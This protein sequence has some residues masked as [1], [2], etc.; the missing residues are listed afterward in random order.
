MYT[1][2][3]VSESRDLIGDTLTVHRSQVMWFINRRMIEKAEGRRD[4]YYVINGHTID[5]IASAARRL[6][7]IE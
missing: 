3:Q 4:W 1:T 7:V 6:P 5:D 2:I